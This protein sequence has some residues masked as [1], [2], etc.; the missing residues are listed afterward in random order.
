MRSPDQ[1]PQNVN[2][3]RSRW[4]R[5]WK[6]I[7]IASALA[8]GGVVMGGWIFV[9]RYLSPLVEDAV[10]QAIDRPIELGKVEGVS[11]S[12]LRFGQTLIPATV[13]DQD[14]VKVEAIEASFNPLEMIWSRKLGISLR[15][16]K[17]EI[18][19]EQDEELNW[20]NLNLKDDQEEPS[21]KIKVTSLRIEEADVTLV[22]RDI[23]KKLSPA[24][25]LELSRAEAEFLDNNQ[26]ITFNLQGQLTD[27]KQ[28]QV[29]G[30]SL[31]NQGST[32]L[33]VSGNQIGARELGY[34]LPLPFQ[35][36]D[37]RID[38]NLEIQLR[39]NKSAAIKGNASLNNVSLKDDNLPQVIKN[40]NGQLGFLGQAIQTNNLRANLDTIPAQVKGKVD[41]NSGFD[42]QIT[43][44]AINISQALSTFSI[45]T[46]PVN[47]QGQVRTNLTITGKLDQPIISGQV[48]NVGIVGIDRFN[49]AN[50]RSNFRLVGSDLSLNNL[51]AEP[52][53]GGII[54]GDGLFQLGGNQKF[55]FNLAINNLLAGE[56]GRIYEFDIPLTNP[57][58]SA[59]ANLMGSLK[60]L[61]NFQGVAT[62]QLTSNNGINLTTN[63][64]ANQ[65][66]WQALITA[67]NLELALADSE[68]LQE[69]KPSINGEFNLAGSTSNLEVEGITGSGLLRIAVAGGLITARNIQL[70]QGSLQTQIR[71]NNLQLN[72]LSFIPVELRESS[73]NGEINATADLNN[74]QLN[75]INARGSGDLTLA[76]GLVTAGNIVVSNSN[77]QTTVTARNIQI[78]R[79]TSVSSQFQGSNINGEFNLAGSLDNFNLEAVTARGF[80]NLGVAGGTV[81]ISNAELVAGNFR[82]LV[83]P[84][85]LELNR[86]ANNLIGQLNGALNI[87]GNINNLSPAGILASGEINFPQGVAAIDRP[88]NANIN[89]NGQRLQINQAT[90][91]NLTAQGF[92]DLDFNNSNII[93]RWDFNINA[94]DLNL[95]NLSLVLPSPVTL[96]GRGD[97]QGRVSGNLV[98]PQVAGNLQVRNLVSTG[99]T[100]APVLS[101]TVNANQSGTNLLLTGEQD[102]IEI[103]LS[104]QFLPNSF[105]VQRGDILAI[106]RVDQNNLLA[107]NLQNFPLQTLRPLI[108][109]TPLAGRTIAGNLSGD[110]NV[111]LNNFSVVGTALVNNPQINTLRGETFTANFTYEQ[112]NFYLSRGSFRRGEA[113]Y[114]IVARVNQ[115]FNTPQI[116]AEAKITNGD[117]QDV[118]TA[119]QI[120]EISDLTRGLTLPT[121][122]NAADLGRLSAGRPEPTL[123]GQLRRLSE[124]QELLAQQ[125]EASQNQAFDL[126]ELRT[127]TGRFNGNIQ[128]SGS[129]AGGINA[130][131]N[132][133]GGG[134]NWG[135]YQ[136]EQVQ[137]QGDFRNN[138][139]TLLPL[140]L[141]D[142]DRV[143]RYQG[144][145]GGAEQ[146][147][148]LIVEK[149]PVAVLSQLLRL[150]SFFGVTG[151][152]SSITTLSGSIDNPTIRGDIN[153]SQ[154]TLNQVPVNQVETSFSYLNSRLRFGTN[155]SV[156]GQQETPLI[157]SGS[158]PYQLPFATTVPSDNNLRLNLQVQNQELAILDL[159]TQGQVVWGGGKGTVQVLITG[160]FDQQLG[161]PTNL[162]ADG[163]AVFENATLKVQV[164]PI[165]LTGIN[166]RIA[167]DFD[168]IRVESLRGELGGGEVTI[169]GNL[170]ISELRNQVEPLTVKL[171]NIVLNL[172]D[173]YSGGVQGNVL[174]TGT[175]L[176]PR[177]GGNVEV[178]D[179]QVLLVAPQQTVAATPAEGSSNPA[180]RTELSNLR[181]TLGRN[182]QLNLPPILNFTAGGNLVVNGPFDDLKPEGT[183]EL[184]RG[185]VNLFTSEFR[186]VGGYPHTAQF[187]RDRGLDPLLNLR[188]ATSVEESTGRRLPTNENLPEIREQPLSA[189]GTVQTVRVEARVNG[190][191]SELSD[192]LELTSSPRRTQPEIIA[193][194]GGNLI[195][196]FSQG[197]ATVGLANLASSAL[198]SNFQNQV[199]DA[200]GLASFRLFPTTITERGQVSSTLGLGAEVGV[201]ITPSLSVSAL[202]VLTANQPFQYSLRYRVNENILLRGSSNFS[203]DNRFL[204]EYENRF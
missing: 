42:L 23:N 90:A 157:F 76:G 165:P 128:A 182:M 29:N 117:I 38:G 141:S 57:L 181:L 193:L 200:L 40:I 145:I 159:L 37:G 36:L 87:R 56:L 124:L 125:R 173:L 168:R 30:E 192:R 3:P 16:I 106:G 137:V 120:F 172:P 91:Q 146:S 17:P 26:K 107:V 147:G 127:A 24:V 28:F 35:L 53:I 7:A 46:L 102:R 89:W 13:K 160:V 94:A 148:Q 33:V 129:L 45:P 34:L 122:G 152:I 113:E 196:S 31:P 164:L 14:Q 189:F 72:N 22:A 66:N 190:Y 185:R 95:Q 61:P 20:I 121:Y 104:P 84:A 97:F 12:S 195:D 194:L 47:L 112:G 105:F 75:T 158:I 144:T 134:W 92:A 115:L 85:G 130:E 15:V 169:T 175:A 154:A 2:P 71:A 5:W 8:T 199:S 88:L 81:N 123:A 43:T 170:P 171:D 77:W 203:G 133:S 98:N 25:P 51:N 9:D 6:P 100:F 119:L 110:F 118:L 183:I 109:N 202:R 70:N 73:L 4:R 184:R 86:F 67:T 1:E 60:D 174:V 63:L 204:I 179:G 99:I 166:G 93:T 162:I 198:L 132:L 103:A 101:G 178:F 55:N 150:P 201:D 167:F 187:S 21:I 155:V 96:A 39:A 135:N 197:N 48:V 156:T 83:V 32:N 64:Q 78:D 114:A 111:D 151:E 41:L 138:I 161:R 49:L 186:L 52:S 69:T 126:P 50:L 58:I 176:A 44:A 153:V 143:V 74:F 108:A 131:F 142:G 180:L 18:Y 116:Q 191:A 82:A 139:L 54:T 11:F 136:L 177:L 149:V 59:N 68:L 10:A 65:G 19:L 80:A 188:L 62:A 27:N 140:R 163:S 79:I